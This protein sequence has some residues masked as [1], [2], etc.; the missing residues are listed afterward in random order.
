M[1]PLT[2]EEFRAPSQ[3]LQNEVERLGIPKPAPAVVSPS[4]LLGTWVNVDHKTRDLVRVMI[5]QQGNEITVHAF[6]ACSPNPCDWNPV[7]GTVYSDSVALEPAV[8]FTALY[9]FG[10]AEV[11]LV[12]HLQKEALF[13]ESLTHFIDHSGRADYYALD[14]MSK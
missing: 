13:V 14:I 8:A 10:F 7:P 3:I 4:P 2:K 9:K 1:S 6:G 11:T 5:A 12:G